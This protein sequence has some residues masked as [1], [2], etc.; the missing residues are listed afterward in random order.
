MK[1]E[2]CS[3]LR[4]IQVGANR[5][6]GEM[7]RVI[8]D[9]KN[10]LGTFV[11]ITVIHPH[12]GEAADALSAS[13][14]EIQ[15]IHSLM[16]V[17]EQDSEV[18]I[19]NRTGRYREVSGDTA[20]VIQRANDFSERSWG[21]FDI[22]VLP[23]VELWKENALQDKVPTN[24]EI[25]RALELVNY[26]NIMQEGNSIEFRKAGMSVTLAGIA[27]GYA[28]DRAILTL[29]ERNI[30]HALVN[31]G[32]D[33]R[34][35]GGKTETLPWKVAIRDPR[36]K[37]RIV[38]SV[39]LFDRAIATSGAYQRPFN[40]IVNPKSGRPVQEI[41]SSTVMTE[42]AMDADILATCMFTLGAEKGIEWLRGL[43]EAE[44]FIIKSDGAILN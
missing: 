3:N 39:D 7:V 19:L 5:K 10:V 34:A 42:N 21:A 27:K 35:L 12:A 1:E 44:A 36:E 26:K 15:R 22:T 30:R 16:S 20:S 13:F 6:K 43:S 33:I 25:S 40:D 18:G 32:G 8:K 41:L 2:V 37:S 11:T 23:L 24:G 31:A 28:V 17:N 4:H 9:V 38:T 29:K 14:K